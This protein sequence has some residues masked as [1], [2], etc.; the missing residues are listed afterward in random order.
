MTPDDIS[1]A[2][3]QALNQ[4]G[5]KWLVA[6]LVALLPALWLATLMLHLGRPYVLRML[7]RMGL[8]FGAD[9]WW[10]GYLIIRDALM[11]VTLG[12]SLIFFQPNLVQNSDLP[13]TGPISALL[14]VLALAVK[15]T[16]RADDRARA[17][18]WTTVF[19]VLGGTLY[20]LA[21]VFAIEAA[22]R[23]YMATFA[24]KF[25]SS[26]NSTPALYI[27]WLSL[28]GIILVGGWLFIWTLNSAGRAMKRRVAA[29]QPQDPQSPTTIA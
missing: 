8:R 1:S 27:M 16:M 24:E 9:I 14:L 21:Q 7:R 3:G 10:M 6:T 28:I 5:E 13:I 19:L 22:D 4:G 23:P 18:R 17:Y 12:M 26:S 11:L 25:T 20:F 15:L 29:S 2:I